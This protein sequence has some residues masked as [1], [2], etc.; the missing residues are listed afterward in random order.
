MPDV[1]TDV[2]FVWLGLTLATTVFAGV[3]FQLPTTAPTPADDV[4]TTIESVAGSPYPSTATHPID[5]EAIRVGPHRLAV[6]TDAGTAHTT[7]EYGPVTP[8]PPGSALATV[9]AGAPPRTVFST[10]TAFQHAIE[11]ARSQQPS[12][13]SSID[14]IVVRTVSWGDHH[15]TLVTA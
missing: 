2:P 5:A 6:R 14:R 9:L 10:P 15:V 1:L 12:W 3:A 8:V 7:I 11:D 13:R 4:A